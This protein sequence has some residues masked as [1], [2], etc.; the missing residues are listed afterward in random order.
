MMENVFEMRGAR[1]A[2]TQQTLEGIVDT[3][4]KRDQ[5]HLYAA[6][7]DEG[8]QAILLVVWDSTTTYYLIGGRRQTDSRHGTNL[9]LWQAI[10]DAA[11][12]GHAFDFEGSMIQGVNQFFQ[13]FGAELT[14]YHYIYKYRGLAR[15]KYLRW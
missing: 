14:P 4:Q 15:Y 1:V 6:R 2:F 10:A 13:K 5:C 9:L 8:I 7:D 12:R 11:Q 3:L